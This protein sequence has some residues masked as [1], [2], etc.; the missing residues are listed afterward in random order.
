MTFLRRLAVTSSGHGGVEVLVAHELLQHVR[1]RGGPAVG[2]GRIGEALREGV[3][4][5]VGIDGGEIEVDEVAV[6]AFCRARERSPFGNRR[7]Q[8]PHPVAQ[9]LFADWGVTSSPGRG[10]E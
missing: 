9:G 4:E 10:G 2:V 5:R 1:R 6:G 7:D 3:A 8:Q